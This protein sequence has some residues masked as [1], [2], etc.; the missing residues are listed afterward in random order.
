MGKVEVAHLLYQRQIHR[1]YSRDLVKLLGRYALPS[2]HRFEHHSPLR[3]R[4]QMQRCQRI[5]NAT[6]FH[7]PGVLTTLA[8]MRFAIRPLRPF[9]Q[10]HTTRRTYHLTQL[11]A[12]T[13]SRRTKLDTLLHSTTCILSSRAINSTFPI[14]LSNP[15]R[16]FPHLRITTH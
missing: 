10:R 9:K 8:D 11:A 13:K 6:V 14:Y 3:G 5:S 12:S 16:I 1:R 15:A 4:I 7:F 2:T